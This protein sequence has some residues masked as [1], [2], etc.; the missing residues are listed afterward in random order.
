MKKFM[1]LILGFIVA[2]GIISYVLIGC[3]GGSS[4]PPYVAQWMQAG[5]GTDILNLRSDGTF[6]DINW[7]GTV[8][9]TSAGFYAGKG[10][11]SFTPD[12]PGDLTQGTLHFNYT[13]EYNDTTDT[14]DSNV[15]SRDSSCVVTTASPKTL[16]LDSGPPY[17]YYGAATTI[18]TTL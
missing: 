12:T 18:P 10:T 15:S 3:G 6:S 2:A 8:G 16:S 17:Q 5:M 11:Y 9:D 4:A 1:I 7:H 14:W 13:H